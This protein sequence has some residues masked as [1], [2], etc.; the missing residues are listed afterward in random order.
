MSNRA[1]WWE[2]AGLLCVSDLHL[3]KSDRVAR[4]TGALL[5]PYETQDTLDRLSDVVEHTNARI[6]VCLGDSFDDLAAADSLNDDARMTIARLQSGRRW[7]WIEGNH[8]PGPVEFGGVHL[9]EFSE[10]P[11]TFRHIATQDTR[12]EISGHFHPKVSLCVRGK[13]ISR[14]SFVFDSQRLLVPAFGAYTGG[15]R[16][17]DP[18]ISELMQP[19]A[20]AI[21]TGQ[22]LHQIPMPRTGNG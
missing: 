8:D 5:P 17:T 15:L 19:D 4:R 2:A 6:V 11:L 20:Q 21:M 7:I 3:G 9:A 22:S 18:A 16:T 14:P 12:G 1:L 10:G 13:L